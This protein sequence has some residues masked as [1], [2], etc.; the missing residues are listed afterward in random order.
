[1]AWAAPLVRDTA[2]EAAREMYQ[3]RCIV[4]DVNGAELF[5]LGRRLMKIGVAAIPSSGFRDLPAS[6]RMVLVDALENP[7]STIGQI[8]E[9]TGFPQSHVSAAVAR[10]REDGVLTTKVDPVDR[11]RT[12]VI[13]SKSHLKKIERAQREMPA[14]D[15]TLE[16]ALVDR[17]GPTGAD[18]LAE[19]TAALTLLAGLV[20]PPKP[21]PCEHDLQGVR[22]C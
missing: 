8:V 17:L 2:S 19:A 9:R 7:G 12:L 21:W 5:L 14:I 1:M 20:T 4:L 18:H 10:L 3:L 11:R 22:T 16:A 15:P 13:A 6:V